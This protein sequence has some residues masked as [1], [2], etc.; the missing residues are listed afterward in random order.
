MCDIEQAPADKTLILLEQECTTT[1]EARP[2]NRFKGALRENCES[3]IR[4]A[5]ALNQQVIRAEK[6]SR[7]AGDVR[8]NIFSREACDKVKH[9]NGEQM[10][11]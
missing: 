3:T 10:L 11:V 1:S 7:R 4:D 6:A 5:R 9:G 2:S 8:R